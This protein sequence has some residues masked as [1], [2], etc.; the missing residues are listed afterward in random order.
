MSNAICLTNSLHRV[1][2]SIC[3]PLSSSHGAHCTV[4]HC[5]SIRI[6]LFPNVWPSISLKPTPYTAHQN[7]PFLFVVLVKLR[8]DDNL[9]NPLLVIF[10]QRRGNERVR[11]KGKT[12]VFS[13][14][15]PGFCLQCERPQWLSQDGTIGTTDET[16]RHYLEMKKIAKIMWIL[17]TLSMVYSSAGTIPPCCK[18]VH[19]NTIR[20]SP[21]M[22]FM[23]F[24]INPAFVQNAIQ[25]H[26]SYHPHSA[27]PPIP[28]C[29]IHPIPAPCSCNIPRREHISLFLACLVKIE[30]DGRHHKESR[31]FVNVITHCIL[32]M[33]V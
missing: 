8:I 14:E 15:K 24:L 4:P 32:F 17:S 16:R 18:L 20:Y 23:I 1:S 3:Q 5:A 26:Q 25:P 2:I 27:N 30:A 7:A 21:P 29:P 33:F 9:E 6:L 11:I 31:P 19:Q 28:H 12:L 10:V 22:F 13:I